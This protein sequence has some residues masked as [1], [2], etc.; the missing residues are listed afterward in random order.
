MDVSINIVHYN[1]PRLLRQTLLGIRRAAPRLNYEVIVVDNNPKLRVREMIEAEF[2]EVRVVVSPR[3]VGFGQGMNK[4]LDHANGRYWLVSN[5]D[6]VLKSGSLEKIV[7]YM[8]QHPDVGI[9]GAKLE[10]PNGEIQHSCYRFME[11]RTVFYRRLPFVN[12]IESVRQHLDQYLMSDWDH[13]SIRDVDHVLGACML[14]RPQAIREVG[15]FD[16]NYFMYF[17]DQDL[18]RR[19]W[20]SGWRVVYNPE[21]NMVHYHRRESAEGGIVKQVLNP[22]THHQI[23]SAFHYFQK[24]KGEA[25]PRKAYESYR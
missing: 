24:F 20:A 3:N 12:R 19:F 13:A 23:R 11:P 10:S 16:P 21:V 17:E 25:N 22:V 4:A 7:E 1:T 8:D 18:C 6:I 5:P 2:P 15:N 9:V 14:V